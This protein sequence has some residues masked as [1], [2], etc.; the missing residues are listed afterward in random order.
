MLQCSPCVYMTVNLTRPGWSFSAPIKCHYNSHNS[1]S[2]FS[3]QGLQKP[4]CS[5]ESLSWFMRVQFEA[6]S[7]CK[8]NILPF[9]GSTHLTIVNMNNACML[10]CYNFSILCLFCTPICIYIT[11]LVVW[12]PFPVLSN[13]KLYYHTVDKHNI[14]YITSSRPTRW[15]MADMS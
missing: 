14:N 15:K 9:K 3:I 2:L 12:I 6:F 10:L 5:P 13:K 8:F 11:L 4:T 1:V 7:H